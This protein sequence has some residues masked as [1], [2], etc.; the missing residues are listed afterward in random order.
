MG[1][2][3]RTLNKLRSDSEAEGGKIYEDEEDVLEDDVTHFEED[4]NPSSLVGDVKDEDAPVGEVPDN[5][6]GTS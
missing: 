3:D 1:L 6:G 2:S 4:D 5:V